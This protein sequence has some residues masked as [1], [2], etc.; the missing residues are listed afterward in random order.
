[1]VKICR[2]WSSVL[3]ERERRP[4]TLGGQPYAPLLARSPF[5]TE[6]VERDHTVDKANTLHLI[7][8]HFGFEDTASDEVYDRVF[9]APLLTT[10]M[11]RCLG[12]SQ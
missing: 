4:T 8:L 2:A 1:M 10:T 6:L 5:Q 12:I 7:G 3:R 9:A 11:G